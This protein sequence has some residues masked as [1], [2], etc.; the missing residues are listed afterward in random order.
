M[1]TREMIE[2]EIK[3]IEHKIFVL[4]MKDRWNNDDYE[5]ERQ[6]DRQI[7]ELKKELANI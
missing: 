7:R 2:K 5:I 4:N 3:N 6:Y 1:R